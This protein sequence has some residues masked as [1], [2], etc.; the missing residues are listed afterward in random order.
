MRI[1]ITWNNIAESL[2][3]E[4]P[5]TDW[6]PKDKA[7]MVKF[8][9]DHLETYVKAKA[10]AGS[11]KTIEDP[12]LAKQFTSVLPSI[13]KTLGNEVNVSVLTGVYLMNEKN[14]TADAGELQGALTAFFKARPDDY[15]VGGGPTPT[16]RRLKANGRPTGLEAFPPR[17]PRSKGGKTMVVDETNGLIEASA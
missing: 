14:S 7:R 8:C 10:F 13:F 4:G 12:E 3:I 11:V 2:Q 5:K 15:S 16:V 1:S 9:K 6:T 17:K